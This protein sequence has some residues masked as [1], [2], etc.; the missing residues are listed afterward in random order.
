MSILD[1]CFCEDNPFVLPQ[2]L[3]QRGIYLASSWTTP[4]K[5]GRVN[6]HTALIEDEIL[7]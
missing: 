2:V 5:K 3:L 7:K 1:V 4:I 6:D